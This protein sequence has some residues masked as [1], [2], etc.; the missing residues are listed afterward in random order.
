[1]EPNQA[2]FRDPSPSATITRDEWTLF[3][4]AGGGVNAPQQ[5]LKLAAPGGRR[6]NACDLHVS[7]PPTMAPVGAVMRLRLLAE[8]EGILS[9]C[10]VVDPTSAMLDA[11]PYNGAVQAYQG[12]LLSVRSRLADAWVLE[13]LPY[14][15]VPAAGYSGGRFVL[16]GWWEGAK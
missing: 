3:P 9:V 12:I 15:T 10:A 11:Y 5:V 4:S 16:G 14:A 6:F 8:L 1:M 2:T 7:L 13:C